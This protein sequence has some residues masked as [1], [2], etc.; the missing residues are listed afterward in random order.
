MGENESRAVDVR[1]V[2]ATNRPLKALVAAGRFRDDLMFRLSVIRIAVPPL[3]ER[4]EDVPSLALA[5]WRQA[6]RRVGT[7]AML[8]PDALALLAELPWPGNVRELQNAMA[9]IAVAAP[10]TGRVG[11]RLAGHVLNGIA[12]VPASAGEIVP[13]E[14]ARRQVERRLVTAALAK[15]T[16]S[17]LAAAS[18]LGLS[19]QGLSKAMRRL[20]LADAGVA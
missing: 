17:R 1:V 13:L 10:A 5:F 11:A 19:R 12:A 4:T 9:A 18:A 6:A 16:G 20:G 14:E 3:R 2:A 8:G 15:H 7:R